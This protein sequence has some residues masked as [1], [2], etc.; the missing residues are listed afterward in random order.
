MSDFDVHIRVDVVATKVFVG[1]QINVDDL[2]KQRH[3]LRFRNAVTIKTNLAYA[4][5]RC[6]N[7]KSGDLVV[8]P[9]CGS[10]T[11]LLEALDVYRNENITVMGMDVSRRSA[12]G[13]R[14]NALAEG[15]N[16]DLC[17]FHC[18]DARNFKKHLED[19]S[20]DAIVTN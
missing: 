9:F 2:S 7:I 6:A 20:V 11:I 5:V 13:A 8:D 16:D 17:Q 19:E 1:T 15:F 12:N 18:C 4:M 3:F 14:E 10:G